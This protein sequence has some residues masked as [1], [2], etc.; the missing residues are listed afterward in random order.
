MK[1]FTKTFCNNV[2]SRLMA[3]AVL[4]VLVASADPASLHGQELKSFLGSASPAVANLSE[5]Q[6]ASGLKEAL[7][8]GVKTAI[9]NLG[10][11]GGFSHDA[12]VRIPPPPNLQRAEKS[13]RAM[14]QGAVVDK[15]IASMNRAAEEAVPEAAEILSDAVRQMSVADAKAILMG[16]NTAATAYFRRTSQGK[17]QERFLPIVKKATDDVGVTKAYKNI[18]DKIN[19]NTVSGFGSFGQSAQSKDTF[20]VDDYVTRKA[21]DGLFQKIAEQERAIRANP[22]A[23]TTDLMQKVFGAVHK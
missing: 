12:A 1:N 16:T 18:T 21:L 6:V 19:L 11:E 7:A 2:G 3:S 14:G 20:N 5:D 4:F 8:K 15:F 13:L 23:R 22:A 9:N 17:L 10:H